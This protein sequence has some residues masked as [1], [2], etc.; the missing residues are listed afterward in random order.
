M[1]EMDV[2]DVMDVS[3]EGAASEG[4]GGDEDMGVPFVPP[5]LPAPTILSPTSPP[6]PLDLDTSLEPVEPSPKYLKDR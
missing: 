6:I 2:L 4:I 5:I 1:D 3:S